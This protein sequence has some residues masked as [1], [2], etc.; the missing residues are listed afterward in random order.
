MSSLVEISPAAEAQIEFHKIR[1]ILASY[2]KGSAGRTACLTLHPSTDIDFIRQR[3][4]EVYEY[5][6]ITSLS[7]RFHLSQYEDITTA[8]EHLPIEGFVLAQAEI[9]ELGRQLE[10][11]QTIHDFF[12]KSERR[13]SFSS[14]FAWIAHQE[15]PSGMIRAIRI[16]LDE[17]GE[18]RPDASPQL[19]SIARSKDEESLRLNRE[20]V[21]LISRYKHEGFLTDTVESIRSGR[22]VLCVQAEYKRQVK[23]IIHD[24][25]TTGRTVFIEPELIVEINNHILEL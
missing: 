23:G 24:E 8:I 9:H 25:S 17:K 20:F 14:V 3:M 2:A 21:K 7:E 19:L 1:E 11:I 18:V 6:D 15:S 13:N 16:I 10:Q 22:R 5:G 12:Y 4:D